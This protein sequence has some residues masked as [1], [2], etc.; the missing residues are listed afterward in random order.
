LSETYLEWTKI[1]KHLGSALASAFK[2][3]TSKAHDMRHDI[4]HFKFTGSLQEFVTLEK[5]QGL[6]ELNGENNNEVLRSRGVIEP[7]MSDY[8]ATSRHLVRGSWF[9]SFL[10]I[11][12]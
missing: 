4:D 8:V 5:Q 1:F 9:F 7:W 3:V 10:S 11:I 2:D 12:Y 6:Q